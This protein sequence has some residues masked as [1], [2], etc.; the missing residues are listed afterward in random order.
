MMSFKRLVRF[1]LYLVPLFLGM[2]LNA[3][4]SLKNFRTDGSCSVL[5]KKSLMDTFQQEVSPKIPFSCDPESG[6]R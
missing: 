4:E 5:D 6:C 2:N 3:Q 1:S